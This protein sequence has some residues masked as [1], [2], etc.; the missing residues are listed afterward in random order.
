MARTVKY[1]VAWGDPNVGINHF[2]STIDIS[3]PNP[4]I[5]IGDV[6][7]YI[8][9]SDI[10]MGVKIDPSTTVYSMQRYLRAWFLDD[11]TTE[12][13]S[14]QFSFDIPFTTPEA[15]NMY[16]FYAGLA[17]P[18]EYSS[19]VKKPNKAAPDT[20]YMTCFAGADRIESDPD[21]LVSNI[22]EENVYG[23]DGT[24]IIGK[25]YYTDYLI[26]QSKFVNCTMTNPTG[27]TK[28]L[29]MYEELI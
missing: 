2:P 26:L 27:A 8:D 12:I 20:S 7:N 19:G 1:Q 11:D 29:M 9:G 3:S 22:Y 14:V 18:T 10:N 16:S 28:I 13:L 5:I 23:V 15:V 24:T 4:L 17:T 21:I 25:K 6:D